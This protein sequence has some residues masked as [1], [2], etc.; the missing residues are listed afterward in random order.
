VH[1]EGLA[2]QFEELQQAMGIVVD[3]DLRKPIFA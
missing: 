3:L 2:R 1:Q